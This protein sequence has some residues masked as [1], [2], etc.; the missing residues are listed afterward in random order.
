MKYALGILLVVFLYSCKTGANISN[1]EL[2]DLRAE[3]SYLNSKVDSLENELQRKLDTDKLLDHDSILFTYRRTPC[4]GNC[5]VFKFSV[6]QDGWA[7]YEGKNYVDM[8][9]VYTARL[10]QDQLNKIHRIFKS[11]FFYSF[12]DEYDDSRLD[13]PSMI[14]EYHGPQGVKQVIARTEIPY[15]FRSLTVELE[16]LAD[17]I[18]W[19]PVE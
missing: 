17:E 13:I 18:T 11:S 14:V 16:E 8:I 7:T 2:T 4:L 10:S 3:N 9:G 15:N 5:S 12:K 1:D 6:Y 19:D